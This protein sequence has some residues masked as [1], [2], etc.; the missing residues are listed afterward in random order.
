M[1]HLSTFAISDDSS[2]IMT[3]D[4]PVLQI[5]NPQNLFRLPFIPGTFSFCVTLG[6]LDLNP[7]LDHTVKLVIKSAEHTDYI[8]LD[9][10]NM[11]VPRNPTFNKDIPMEA[12]GVLFNLD[13]RNLPFR[14]E[15]KYIAEV[16][17]DD[18]LIDTKNFFM[19]T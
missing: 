4:G 15:G 13:F 16:H 1:P 9:S 7:E 19:L 14:Y 6:I 2:Q 5:I 12:H 8:A 10:N 3:P 17:V 11:V 18:K